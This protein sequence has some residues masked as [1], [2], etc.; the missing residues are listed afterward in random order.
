MMVEILKRMEL[1]YFFRDLFKMKSLGKLRLRYSDNFKIK[2][3]GVIKNITIDQSNNLFIAPNFEN[4]QKCSYIEKLCGGFFAR[5]KEKLVVL[6]NIGL[7]YFNDPKE[8]P[9]KLIPIIGSEIN[10]VDEKKY[11][12]KN[13]F[14]IKTL[15]NDIYVFAVKTKDDLDS[16]IKE[17]KSFKVNYQKMLKGV[18]NKNITN[19]KQGKFIKKK[20]N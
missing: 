15:N 19:D 1:L 7:M 2:Q 9:R 6:T 14:Q 8:P 16:W 4:A 20:S 5:F 17:F 18:D 12:K 11:S 10:T 13:C 3:G